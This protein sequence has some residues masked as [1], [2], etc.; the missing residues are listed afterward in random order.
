[1]VFGFVF[2]VIFGGILYNADSLAMASDDTENGIHKWIEA[3]LGIGLVIEM[4][5]LVF[6]FRSAF[7]VKA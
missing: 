5:T 4:S 1:M 3:T 2:L 7:Y 6:N